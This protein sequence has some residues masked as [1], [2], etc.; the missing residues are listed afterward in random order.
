MPR[1]DIEVLAGSIDTG[2]SAKSMN[3]GDEEEAV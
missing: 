2:T 3:D 1:K